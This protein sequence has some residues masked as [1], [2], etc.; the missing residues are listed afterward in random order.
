[1]RPRQIAWWVTP[2]AK[3]SVA[4]IQVAAFAPPVSGGACGPI[5]SL[6]LACQREDARNANSSQRVDPGPRSMDIVVV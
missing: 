3:L 6:I 5:D 1:M 2:I 4:A